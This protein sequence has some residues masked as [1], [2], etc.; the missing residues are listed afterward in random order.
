MSANCPVCGQ[1]HI[2]RDVFPENFDHRGVT[3]VA[4]RIEEYCDAC[5]TLLQTP[6][7]VR[8]NSRNKQR[9]IN[10]HEGMLTGAQIQAMR[11]QFGLTQKV[12]AQLFGGGPTAF[13]KYEAD[14]ISHNLSMDR[15]LRLS[16]EDPTCIL[17]L[18]KIAEL[19]LPS[20]VQAN[21]NVCIS[22]KLIEY[23]R[24]AQLEIDR[25]PKCSTRSEGAS[26]G[27]SIK[28]SHAPSH[29]M[30]ADIIPMQSWRER[31]AA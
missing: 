18:A 8:E 3:L 26:F 12:A 11:E 7:I 23:A 6:E 1:G 9:A 17:R 14:E 29:K 27:T 13:A 4:Q 21:I 15:L 30:V 20:P 5:G 2:T 28:S 22:A 19:T 24:K 16:I 31:M 25:Y 10:Q